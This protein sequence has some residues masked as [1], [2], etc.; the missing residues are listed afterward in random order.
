VLE[1]SIGSEFA[2]RFVVEKRI[3]SGGMG[4]IFRAR[5]RQT[6]RPVALKLMQREATSGEVERFM[7]EARTLSEL[8]HP[9]IVS[10][11][12]HGISSEGQP[13]LV[14]EWLEG[15]DLSDRLRRIRMT[16]P[17]VIILL[18]TVGAAL[19]TAHQAGVIHRD[20]KPS[21][22]FLRDGQLERTT[23][24]DF[25]LA[26]SVLGGRRSTQ[27]GVV[28]GTPEY[29]SPEQARGDR[30][31]GP[32]ADI[33][34]LG[35]VAF[36]CLTGQPP[37]VSEHIAS[38]L[39]KILFEEPPPL[40][41]ACPDAPEP[42]V[43]LFNK[44]LA[45]NPLARISDATKLLEALS[46][47][48]ELP[49]IS[50]PRHGSTTG[51]LRFEM[52]GTEQAL[53]SV[54]IAQ[55]KE[56]KRD[57]RLTL[58]PVSMQDLQ[59]QG[60][61]M[62]EALIQFGVN[63][64]CMVD[65]SLI[66]S[67]TRQGAASDQAIHAARCALVIK[68][69]W[70][71][72]TV[73]LATGRAVLDGGTMFGEVLGRVGKMIET[74]RED[75]QIQAGS[76]V[77]DK[78]TSRLCESHFSIIRHKDFRLLVGYSQAADESRPLLGVPTP[79][80]GRE[81]E[82][83]LLEASFASCRDNSTAAVVLVSS[84]AGVGKSRLRHEFLR[85]V[86]VQNAEALVMMGRGDPMSV[87]ASYGLLAQALRRLFGLADTETPA[88]RQQ[89]IRARVAESVKS[90]EVQ[91]V[92]EFLG[93]ICGTQFPESVQLRAARQDPHV[94]SDQVSQAFVE[95]LSAEC[96][97]SQTVLLILEDLHWGD[98]LTVRIVDVALRELADQPLMVLALARPEVE[99]LFPALW[100]GR[101]RQDIRLG[102][103]PK[104]AC[105]RL[106]QQVLGSK[107]APAVLAR[108]IEQA[109]GN[110]LF[111]EELVRAVSEGTSDEL[112]ET[113]LAIL[114][115]RLM[116]LPPDARRVLRTASVFGDTFW[117]GGVRKLL[118]REGT[119]MKLAEWLQI[120]VEAEIIELR[121]ESRIP[122]E[123]EYR[124]RHGLVREAAYGMLPDEERR[125]G[126]YLVGCYLEEA[127]ESDPSVLAE[128][129]HR[130]GD[131]ARATVLY[132]RAAEKAYND[133]DWEGV[134]NRVAKGL[135][136]GAEGETRGV[137]IQ[138]QACI[139]F[140]RND[141][142]A[143]YQLGMEAMS[144]LAVGTADWCRACIA[145]LG[146]AS[147]LGKLAQVAE[148]AMRFGSIVPAPEILGM[149]IMGTA[150][151]ATGL[152]F[153]G[154]RDLSN[155][156]MSHLKEFAG[157]IEGTDPTARSW[158]H[159]AL[160][161]CASALEPKPYSAV[162]H[163]RTSAAA[164]QQTGD[165]RMV[166][167]AFGDLGFAL[168]RVGREAEGESILRE[169]L[170]LAMRIGEEIP[171]VWVRMYLANVLS[172]RSDAAG[173]EEAR[174][175]AHSILKAIGEASYYSGLAYCAL[176]AVNRADGNLAQ[177][178]ADARKALGILRYVASHAPLAFI[179]LSQVLLAAGRIDEAVQTAT[180]GMGVVKAL[181]GTGGSE[182][183][184]RMTYIAALR[185]QNNLEAVEREEQEL[186]RQ[187][188]LR[189]QDFADPSLRDSY[190]ARIERHSA[191]VLHS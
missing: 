142:A 185:A 53:V 108:I 119:Q 70:P 75:S 76:V 82:L 129:F 98:A 67:I 79:C 151:F 88:V 182:V 11:V 162:Q 13:Y 145:T 106:V 84:P 95:F 128:H 87:G 48:G 5:D 165:R 73:A 177:A 35:C 59:S 173:R 157:P 72:S 174:Q 47:I 103:L 28:I 18:R 156:F 62:R 110:A 1:L 181:G 46:D 45:K 168:S 187:I 80:V 39:A 186:R 7:R 191:M 143:A 189:I 56:A 8:R 153:V 138:F 60:A 122:G 155:L 160:G 150:L 190:L 23:L 40:D 159:Y 184:L 41:T 188:E 170:P 89:K 115:A 134:L 136:C 20:I 183:P 120:Q 178:E 42:L 169:M 124:F 172:E 61:S 179:A 109:A 32:S 100:S 26:R 24:I 175:I 6:N 71:D 104:R 12:A 147:A 107:V 171:I 37:F 90:G 96:A 163:F 133:N 57:N 101:A 127:G 29:M 116:R 77:I 149:Y 50:P 74:A 102:G 69:R 9:S 91:R 99:D 161:R 125:L 4:M 152:G 130:S 164:F 123:I 36:E 139:G 68:E 131:F 166:V 167:N 118:G 54:V 34:S 17:E 126:H 58:D 21:N 85:R 112:P 81:R 66:A 30:Q 141:L 121:K 15:E 113:V 93:E 117:E 140:W 132:A 14:M 114:H 148:L 111:L 144:L 146:A 19:Q 63:V 83:S 38:V 78:V 22:L 49:D 154:E 10:Y 64:E 31:I 2:H 3:Q 16:V 33:F 94:M 105:E 180:E 97:K 25:G 44:M 65:G 52:A 51:S 176:A 86:E 137:L 27:T 92:A 158:L 55:G 135:E 43:K